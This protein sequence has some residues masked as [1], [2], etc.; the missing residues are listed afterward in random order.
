[1]TLSQF[2]DEQLAAELAKREAVDQPSRYDLFRE[3]MALIG[4][5]EHLKMLWAAHEIL[6]D[7]MGYEQEDFVERF[8]DG[9]RYQNI[10]D[11]VSELMG[12]NLKWEED[13]AY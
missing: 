5:E 3:R 12:K 4:F 11:E 13:D 9:G 6:Q 8:N 10:V 7:Y 2:T 1:M